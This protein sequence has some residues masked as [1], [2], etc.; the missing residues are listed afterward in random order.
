MLPDN[1]G[2]K[3]RKRKEASRQGYEVS[4]NDRRTHEGGKDN[5]EHLHAEL[6]LVGE[7][8][9]QLREDLDK[10]AAETKEA[11]LILSRL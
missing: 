3:S 6:L 7:L 5:L 9:T 10:E 1:M 8:I 2:Y 11:T 4:R